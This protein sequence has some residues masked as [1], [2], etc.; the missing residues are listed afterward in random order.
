MPHPLAPSCLDPSPPPFAPLRFLYTHL[1]DAIR[2]ELDALSAAVLELEA[3]RRA[4]T[5]GDEG[6]SGAHVEDGDL[7][8]RLLR[9][10]DRY[11]FLEQVYK[12]HSSVEDEVRRAEGGCAPGVRRAA[13]ASSS[14]GKPCRVGI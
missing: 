2:S 14:E 10:Q 12:Y 1:H 7:E 4:G 11:R 6:N 5:V 3:S 13:R 9:L 8:A